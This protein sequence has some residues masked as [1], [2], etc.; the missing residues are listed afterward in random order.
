MKQTLDSLTERL[1]ELQR[2][3]G[4]AFARPQE[5]STAATHQLLSI[6]TGENRVMLRLA[7]VAGI[8]PCPKLVALPSPRPGL[9]GVVG[10]RGRVL[11]VYSMAALLGTARSETQ[12]RWLLLPRASDQMA[13]GVDSIE[14]FLNVPGSAMYPTSGAPEDA[15]C[16]E[17]V[18]GSATTHPVLSISRAVAAIRRSLELPTP[19][20]VAKEP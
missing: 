3:F 18:Q 5:S 13:L 8:H 9:L 15:L 10:V 2:H 11:A 6:R 7:E 4:E 14:A 16:P 19:A 17:I 1:H 12:P 20:P